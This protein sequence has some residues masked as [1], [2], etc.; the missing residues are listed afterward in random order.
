MMIDSIIEV[1]ER[2]RYELRRLPTGR[3]GYTHGFDV[4]YYLGKAHA[5]EELAKL[6]STDVKEENI[7]STNTGNQK[8]LSK[9]INIRD[10]LAGCDQRDHDVAFNE[11]NK[12][13]EQLQESLKHP[14]INRSEEIAFLEKLSSNI[15]K[16]IL[17]MIKISDLSWEIHDR[18]I[19]LRAKQRKSE[20]IV[21]KDRDVGTG[22]MHLK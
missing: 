11:L 9:L 21:G 10:C 18:I 2:A 22:L 7:T 20:F 19:N 6:C 15:T 16:V 5:A 17:G 14:N 3:N 1:A 13:I 4:G 12:I 8:L